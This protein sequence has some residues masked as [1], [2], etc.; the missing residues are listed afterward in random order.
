MTKEE[1]VSNLDAVIQKGE[2]TLNSV[3]AASAKPAP[4]WDPDYRWVK[5][6]IASAFRTAGLSALE[7][8]YGTTHRIYKD[9]EALTRDKNTLVNYRKAHALICQVREEID[10]TPRTLTRQSEASTSERQRAAFLVHGHDD[11]M[12]EFVARY[13]EQ[14]GIKPI[15]LHEQ[16]SRGRTVIEKLERHANVPFAVVLLTP[17]D[18]GGAQAE[19]EHL[20]SRARQNVVLELGFF[21]GRLGRER[22]CA[23]Y[24]GPLELPSDYVGVVYVPFDEAGGWRLLL[25]RELKAAGFAIDMNQAI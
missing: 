12:R 4:G 14:L 2:Q 20:Q 8:V 6:D 18:L 13:L 19:R 24:K 22:V 3:E 1:L 7:A 25:A 10:R 17:D 15:I 9:F 16:A 21:V 11:G 5:P 23:L